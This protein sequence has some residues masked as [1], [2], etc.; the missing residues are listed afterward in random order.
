MSILK[1][2]CVDSGI[3]VSKLYRLYAFLEPLEYSEQGRHDK[4]LSERT[5]KHTAHCGGTEG[6]VAV[7]AHTRCKHQR[8]Q[9]DNHC[10]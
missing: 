8:Q 2:L 6:L 9:T 7:L 4:Q 5:D 10:Q 1:Q 3:V